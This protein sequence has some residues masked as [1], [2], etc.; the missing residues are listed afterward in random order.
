MAQLIKNVPAMWETRVQ[1][2]GCED[3]LEKE[4]A[5]TPVLWTREFHG[6][7]HGATKS[8]H[9]WATFTFTLSL[10]TMG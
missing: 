10:F 6:T 8:G 4:K 1:S 3:P 7:V 9:D 5:T 2:L